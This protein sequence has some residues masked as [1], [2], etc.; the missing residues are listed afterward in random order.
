MKTTFS[1]TKYSRNFL[2]IR[3]L[4]GQKRSN[5]LKI[6][7]SWVLTGAL[8][9]ALVTVLIAQD[10]KK[11]SSYSPVV[12]QEDF[13]TVMNRMS[14]DKP[15]IMK[16]QKALLE[17]RYDLANRPASGVTMSRKSRPGGRARKTPQRDDL[18]Q[19]GAD[20]AGGDPRPGYLSRGFYAASTPES[21]L[22]AA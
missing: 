8:A 21:S 20:D 22:K 11:P 1:V 18:G 7:S 9:T 17:E 4:T 12:I 19:V 10:K 14:A 2:I 13:T 5:S 15:A 6:R 3:G 16:R